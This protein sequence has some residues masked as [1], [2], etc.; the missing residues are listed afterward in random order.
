MTRLIAVVLATSAAAA[1][2]AD[3]KTHRYTCKGGNFTVT[4]SIDGS[5]RWSRSEPV[6]L[7]IEGEPAQT[8]VADPDAPEAASYKNKDY[9]F[10]ALKNFVRLTRMSHRVVVKTYNACRIE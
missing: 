3:S 1:A 5:G 10:Y 6:I 7:R 2:A 4:A 9:E 8:L